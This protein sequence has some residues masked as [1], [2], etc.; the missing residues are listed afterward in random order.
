[1]RHFYRDPFQITLSNK[2]CCIWAWRTKWLTSECKY[3]IDFWDSTTALIKSTHTY[4]HQS[5]ADISCYSI[6][7][8]REWKPEWGLRFKQREKQVE[9]SKPW[10][11][12]NNIVWRFIWWWAVSLP[13]HTVCVCL[14]EYECLCDCKV[15]IEHGKTSFCSLISFGFATLIQQA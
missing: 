6:Q 12:T 13:G 5:L 9:S 11:H 15:G 2:N 4:G 3:S 1:M 8:S 7:G 14:C 10:A